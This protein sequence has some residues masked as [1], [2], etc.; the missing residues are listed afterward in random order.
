MVKSKDSFSTNLIAWYEVNKRNLPWR[1]TSD[2]Y[3]IWL[4][5]IILQQTRV[6]QGMPYYHQFVETFPTVADL[7]AAPQE[8]VLKLWQGLGYY[9][10]ARNLHIAAQYV[11]NDLK[12]KFPNTYKDL[13]SLKGVG[14]Y[15][16]SAVGSICFN[17]PTA[18][19]DGNVY[20][21][22]SRV[23][24]I[25]TAINTTRGIKEFKALAQ[26]LLF[27]KDTGTYNQAVMDFGAR[28]CT[29]VNPDC[30]TCIFKSRCIAF[31]TEKVSVL[32]V[33]LKKTKARKRYFNYLVILDTDG[34]TRLKQRT[35]KGIWQQ[36][37]EFPLV[38]TSALVAILEL[39]DQEKYR[40]VASL[41]DLQTPVLF[42]DTP[43]I[44]KLSHQHLYTQFWIVFTKKAITNGVKISAL[45][46][47]PVPVLIEKFIS[48]FSSF[49]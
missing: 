32:P 5:E 33:K 37:Y 7:A 9:S 13:L 22:L 46:D 12:G 35:E 28:H 14:D 24:G 29:P 49:N 27:E 42:N 19:V 31:K 8:Q 6:D 30:V 4:S 41:Y 45:R 20:R 2:P 25:E 26:K 44:H 21:V 11:A 16:A 23:F 43:I 15:T 17:L 34:Q 18:V 10:R 48:K 40:E 39:M 38:E 1:E 47:Y 36:L 3:V